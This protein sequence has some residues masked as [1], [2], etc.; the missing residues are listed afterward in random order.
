MGERGRDITVVIANSEDESVFNCID[1]ANGGAKIVVSL[2]PYAPIE[3]RLSR[4][5]IPFVVVPRG[6]LSITYNSGIELATTNKV[7]IMDS[8]TVFTPRAIEQLGHGLEQYDA[9]KARLSFQYDDTQTL[10]GIVANARDFINSSPT[11]AYTPGLALRKDIRNQ[12]GGYFFNEQIRWAVDSEFSYRFHK[13]GLQFGY[14]PDAVVN[15][16][17]VSIRHDL[18]EAFLMGLSKRR[19]VDLGVR[20][21][22]EDV[23]PTLKRILSGE[24]FAKRGKLFKEKGVS[25]LLYM[26][27][28]DLLYNFGY[29][30][31]KLGLSGSTE[32]RIWRGFGR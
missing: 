24:T 13:N 2:T 29:N 1:S 27:T 25:T 32:E 10:S 21:G 17:A 26:L 12:M 5:N 6:N 11:R 3:A 31:R 15:H 19:A 23:L 30:L 22:N 16:P 8:D 28:W 14:I 9:C 7:I 18:T 20:E 4:L